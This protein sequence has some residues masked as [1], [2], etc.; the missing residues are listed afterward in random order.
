MPSHPGI[1]ECSTLVCPD[2]GWP[3]RG[4]PAVAHP[5]GCRRWHLHRPAL[6]VADA[7]A[8]RFPEIEDMV[9]ADPVWQEFDPS[10]EIGHAHS[11][12]SVIRRVSLEIG[13]V[14]RAS[15]LA[16]KSPSGPPSASLFST[17]LRLPGSGCGFSTRMM[18]V[19]PS[20]CLCN[21]LRGELAVVAGV[22]HIACYVCLGF[23]FWFTSFLE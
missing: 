22:Q 16:K 20:H 3:P 4:T 5:F 7:L 17:G 14:G 21:L 15:F 6:L 13:S 8:G 9:E 12:D 11:G 10:L 1:E 19:V 18:P 23:H 2:P